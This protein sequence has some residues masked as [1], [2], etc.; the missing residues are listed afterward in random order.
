M[1][2]NNFFS[3]LPTVEEMSSPEL[4]LEWKYPKI[5]Q[6]PQEIFQAKSVE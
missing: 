4:A 1:Y 6:R 5:K 3:W 2:Y